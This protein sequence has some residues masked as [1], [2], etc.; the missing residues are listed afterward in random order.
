MRKFD[1]DLADPDRFVE[2]T[3]HHWFR[4]LRRE[5]PV[6]FH[7]EREG[8]GFW[9]VTRH[10][11]LKHVSRNPSIFSSALGG[12]TL[13]DLPEEDLAAVRAIMLNMDPPQ[14]VKFRRVVSRAF[15]PRRVEALR[16][17]VR[18]IARR[19]VDGVADKGECDFVADVAAQLPLEVICEMMGVPESDRGGVFDLSNRL[20]GFDDPDFQTNEADGKIAAAEMFTYAFHLAAKLKQRPGEDI[21]SQLL[22]AEVDGQRLGETE[23]ASLF[24]LLS[25]AGNETT[26][27][28][29][30]WGMHSLIEHPEER[31]RLRR[32]PS[33]LPC[34]VEEIVRYTPP[35]H[36]MRRTTTCDTEISG[37]RLPA[38]AKVA[39]WYP[40]ANRD[41]AVFS[42]P[43]RFDVGRRPNPHLSFG[44]GEHFCLG[45][46][47]ARLELQE[48]FAALLRRIPEMELVSA[49][50]RLRSNFVNGCKSMH[51]RYAPLE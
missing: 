19:I 21:V 10:E 36:Y 14:H 29:T 27:T 4:Q 34:A 7:D 46:H 44:I 49:P 41:E 50:R 11:D 5:A 47:L 38:G 45:A 43:D 8:P 23:F 26:R 3:P 40:S 33:L 31:E 12:T 17:H 20:I 25:I 18:S 35:V 2:G 32:D 9:C 6:Y 37:V 16:P 13:Q 48:I 30:A 39:L 28:V 24:L 42:D 22:A 51:V 15:T 1:I